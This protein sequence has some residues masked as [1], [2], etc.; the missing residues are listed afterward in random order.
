[1][2]PRPQLVYGSFFTSV[3]WTVRGTSDQTYGIESFANKIGFDVFDLSAN[4]KRLI[5][6]YEGVWKQ[7]W[8]D[9]I[10]VYYKQSTVY[11]RANGWE[12]NATR[13]P[14]YNIVSGPSNWRFDFTMRPLY[15]VFVKHHGSSSHTCFPHGIIGQSFDYDNI[16][17]DGRTDN[18]K[19]GSVIR[20]SAMAEG[21]I[22]GNATDYAVGGGFDTNFAYSRFNKQLTDTCATRNVSALTG[23]KQIITKYTNKMAGSEL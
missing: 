4:S 7:W 18:Y 20:T 19:T 6:R 12:V 10:R 14:I 1:M 2:L 16:R 13:R 3:A 9:G 15:G 21:A 17:V 5:K 23:R 8:Y 22:E 11:I